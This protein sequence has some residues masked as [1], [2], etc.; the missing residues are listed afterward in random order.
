[1]EQVGITE[2]EKALIT[3]MS[4]LEYLGSTGRKRD[5]LGNVRRY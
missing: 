2:E 5:E 1:M 3:E 4:H